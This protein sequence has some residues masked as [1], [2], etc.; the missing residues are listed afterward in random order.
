LPDFVLVVGIGNRNRRDDGAGPRVLELVQREGVKARES[1]EVVP[2]MA[3]EV[4]ESAGVIFVD[5][6][7]RLGPVSMEKITEE[8]QCRQALQHALRVNDVVGLARRLYKW[9]GEAWVVKV[10]GEDFGE[11]EGLSET[12]ERNVREAAVMVGG[13][14]EMLRR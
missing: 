10:P 11:G 4:A 14:L 1:M 12:G 13:L 2:E 6:D 9:D 7:Y 8:G 5:A 3:A